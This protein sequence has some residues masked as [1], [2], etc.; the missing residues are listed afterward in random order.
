MRRNRTLAPLFALLIAAIPA[1]AQVTVGGGGGSG[2]GTTGAGSTGS[3]RGSGSQSGGGLDTAPGPDVGSD[4]G[5]GCDTSGAFG[6]V[7]IPTA[8]G[9]LRCPGNRRRVALPGPRQ[10]TIATIPLPTGPDRTS[11]QVWWEYN[12]DAYLDLRRQLDAR[13]LT[14]SDT[15]FL[16]RGDTSLARDV[17]RPSPDEIA[18]RVVPALADTL[19]SASD[20]GMLQRSMIALARIAPAEGVGAA[21]DTA[22]IRSFH[23]LLEHP[24]QAVAETAVLSLGILGREAAVPT[25]IALL[26]DTRA[27]WKLAGQVA[28][29]TRTRAFAA[30][31]L[32]LVGARSDDV[33]FK[34]E[35]VARL[36]R[37][38]EEPHFSTRD[39]KIAAM[40]AMGLTALPIDHSTSEVPADG[41]GPSAHWGGGR[42][43][44]RQ[45]QVRFLE[46]YFAPENQ[47]RYASTRHW[48]VRAHA[49]TALARLC[50]DAPPHLRE[51]VAELLIEGFGPRSSEP[52]EVQ[53]SCIL[54][55]GRIA[56]ADAAPEDKLDARIR[57]ELLRAVGDADEIGRRFALIALARAGSR[58]G[59]GSQPWGAVEPTSAALEEVLTSGGNVM[60]PWAALALGIQGH[61]LRQQGRHAPEQALETLRSAC[62]DNRRPGECGA[63]MIALGL[64]G[65]LAASPILLEKIE[66]FTGSDR[67]RG[68]A[69]IALGLMDDGHATPTVHAMLARS[70]HRPELLSRAAI[71]LGLLGDRR[72]VPELMKQ[73][74]AASSAMVQSS[75]ASALGYIGDARSI[76]PLTELLTNE[77]AKNG[78][79][80]WA[81]VALGRL[82]DPE[83]LPWPSI[84]AADMNYNAAPATLAEPIS[85]SGVLN[86]F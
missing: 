77:R 34:R 81:A 46:H 33:D 68:D 32:G 29:P 38:L 42:P 22:L 36:V 86:L 83:P 2:G 37:I 43:S 6:E 10:A 78:A 73:L 82:C 52:Q 63:L 12:K 27:G 21:R 39:V 71:G 18:N 49:P 5:T 23:D 69:A 65:D 70:I 80:A 53:Q 84:L 25:L 75:V 74:A 4:D 9:G 62:A 67:A 16:G 60:R 85:G 20:P 50:D 44:T 41:Q 17:R 28:V 64:Q 72:L 15:F 79:R 55:L 56:D 11:W 3:T 14:G 26:E 66:L 7:A 31:A 30:Y 40:T 61:A 47:R 24:N 48:L 19:A 8:N 13:V 45:E 51:R 57:S 59:T 35:I 1:G 76:D 58:R 54:A